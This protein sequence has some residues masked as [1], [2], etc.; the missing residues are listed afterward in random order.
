MSDFG[1]SVAR[2]LVVSPIA[3]ADGS[4]SSL[5]QAGY[6][7]IVIL[8]LALFVVAI[9]IDNLYLTHLVNMVQLMMVFYDGVYLSKLVRSTNFVAY[10]FRIP[11]GA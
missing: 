5:I 7:D 8:F 11:K 4:D 1:A 10:S 2:L 6:M 9:L 3:T